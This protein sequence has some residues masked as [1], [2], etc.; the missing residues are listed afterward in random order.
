MSR[1]KRETTFEAAA[2]FIDRLG[3]VDVLIPAIRARIQRVDA[4]EVIDDAVDYIRRT[5]EILVVV[6]GSLTVTTGL[7]VYL[8]RRAEEEARREE[9]SE[10]AATKRRTPAKRKE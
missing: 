2:G 9:R 5:P 8:M 7:I 6:L 3:L 10:R 1:A 4:D